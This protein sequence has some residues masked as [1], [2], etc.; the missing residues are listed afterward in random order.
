VTCSR[1]GKNG[2]QS[3][4]NSKP[5]KVAKRHDCLGKHPSL[6]GLQADFITTAGSTKTSGTIRS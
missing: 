6:K 1:F 4:N 5:F 3:I 2:A